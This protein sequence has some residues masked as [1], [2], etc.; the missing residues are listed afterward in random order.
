VETVRNTWKFRL[1]LLMMV[2]SFLLFSSHLCSNSSKP[3][4]F[5]H[6]SL[7]NFSF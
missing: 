2:C 7:D 3:S 1:T 6:F 4:F 5:S